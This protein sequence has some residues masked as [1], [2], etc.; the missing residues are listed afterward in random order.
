VGVVY[1]PALGTL[2]VGNGGISLR[3]YVRDKIQNAM[4]ICGVDAG[5]GYLTCG[6]A[7]RSICLTVTR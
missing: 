5:S 2:C 7:E 6:A 4:F 1:Q 3:E